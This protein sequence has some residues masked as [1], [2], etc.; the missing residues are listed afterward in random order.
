M[1]NASALKMQKVMFFRSW[2]KTSSWDRE[3]S[4]TGLLCL[5]SPLSSLAD[6]R[7]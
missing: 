2:L 1:A 7:F 5:A 3:T 4:L 6:L